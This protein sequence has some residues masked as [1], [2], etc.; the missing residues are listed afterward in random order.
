MPTLL[1]DLSDDVL[2]LSLVQAR[3][4]TEVV[5]LVPIDLK[6]DA[7]LQIAGRYRRDWM[8]ARRRS[9]IPARL[10]EF[11]ADNLESSLDVVLLGDIEST[12][13]NPLRLNTT[14][15]RIRAGLRFDAPLTRLQERNTYRQALIEYQRQSGATTRHRLD[16]PG[17]RNILR[18]ID[19]NQSI[20]RNA[21]SPCSALSIRSCSTT[22]FKS[23]AR[24]A[25]WKQASRP[26][27]TSSQP[28]EICRRPERFLER[29]GQL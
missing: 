14:G 21:A 25:D 13:D 29:L 20:S 28:W 6:W 5:Q 9:S 1:S 11:N 15:G 19:L 3:A 27:G 12:G 23:C 10:I 2:D 24:N 4:R 7:A 8:N 22:R 26:P 18:T 17:L 16:C